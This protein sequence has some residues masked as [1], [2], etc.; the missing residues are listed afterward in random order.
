M[1]DDAEQWSALPPHSN[2]VVHSHWGF[3]M[4]LFL[5]GQCA[6]P[7]TFSTFAT[8]RNSISANVFVNDKITQPHGEAAC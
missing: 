1:T 7:A 6:Q 8:M 5:I 3:S 4:W 2:K